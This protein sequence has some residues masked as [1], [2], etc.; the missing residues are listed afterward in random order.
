MFLSFTFSSYVLFQQFLVENNYCN[1]TPL[2]PLCFQCLFFVADDFEFDRSEVGYREKVL[3]N[4]EEYIHE[5]FRGRSSDK[6]GA[7]SV[8]HLY[9]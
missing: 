6:G 9:E 7:F 3:K 2:S 5:I 1:S 8:I 4:L